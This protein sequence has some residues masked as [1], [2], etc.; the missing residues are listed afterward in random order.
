MKRIAGSF[1]PFILSRSVS[2]RLFV[3]KRHPTQIDLDAANPDGHRHFDLR[4]RQRA[5][6]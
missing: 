2:G 4:S 1:L 6:M 3:L 5:G